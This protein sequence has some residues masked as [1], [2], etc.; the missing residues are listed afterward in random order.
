MR[1]A[2]RPDNPAVLVVP[3]VKA[4]MEAQLSVSFLSLHDLLRES[5]ICLF[6]RQKGMSNPKTILVFPLPSLHFTFS[7]T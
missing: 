6:M 4:R 3:N 2:R 5:F 7:V 1:P